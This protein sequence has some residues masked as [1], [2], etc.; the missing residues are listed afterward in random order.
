MNH[1]AEALAP[2]GTTI[3]AEITALAARHG[4]VDL[5]QG[6]PDFDG[7]DFVKKAAID[8]IDN[9]HNQYARTAGIAPLNRIIAHNWHARTGIEIDPDTQVT[10]TTGCT[11]GIAAALLGLLNPGDEII[12]FEPY[13]DSYPALTARVGATPRYVALRPDASGR[14]TFDPDDLKAAFSDHTRAIMVNTPHNPTGTVFDR[15]ELECIADL[16]RSRD[17]IAITD[18]VYEHLVFEGA[19]IHLQTLP[20]MDE[21]TITLSSL[22]KTFS[23]TGWKVG[24][25]IASEELSRAVRAAHQF[26]TFCTATPFQ[27]GAVAALGAPASY[28]ERFV[29]EYRSKRD[30]LCDSLVRIGFKVRPPDGTYFILAD[31]SAFGTGDD[32]AFVRRLIEEIG[33]AAI[34]PTSFYAHPEHGRSLVRF[35]F[36]KREETLRSAVARLE[37]LA[38]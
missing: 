13:Y 9:H 19:H 38:R 15:S 24:W 33:V 12:L 34:P 22:G 5:S 10:V 31:H 3:F 6:F 35:A 27:H 26:I 2:F 28:Y 1:I 14:F 25:A 8:A 4:A 16:C 29:A 21:R 36:C 18:E 17:V 20:G 32:V 23:L 37:A 30:Y 7:P 11:E